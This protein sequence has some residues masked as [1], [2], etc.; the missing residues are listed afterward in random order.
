MPCDLVGVKAHELGRYAAV[1]GSAR[2][3]VVSLLTWRRGRTRPTRFA[4]VSAQ[5]AIGRHCFGCRRDHA[6]GWVVRLAAWAHVDAEE[7][8]SHLHPSLFGLFLVVSRCFAKFF[9]CCNHPLSVSPRLC[10]RRAC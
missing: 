1:S 8:E 9:Q 2:Q 3:T 5:V 7:L 6:K 10:Y 4:I